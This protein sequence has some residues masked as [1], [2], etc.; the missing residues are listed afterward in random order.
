M[1]NFKKKRNFVSARNVDTLKD[2]IV[3]Q[4]IIEERIVN[5]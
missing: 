2:E 3:K 1:S 5:I 4:A